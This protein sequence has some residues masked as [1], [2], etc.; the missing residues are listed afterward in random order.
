[1]TKRPTAPGWSARP[2]DHDKIPIRVTWWRG[3]GDHDFEEYDEEAFSSYM[4]ALTSVVATYG[5]SAT[6]RALNND[7]GGGIF[8]LN[9]DLGFS[10]DR[11]KGDN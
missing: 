6:H 10:L 1:M 3:V 11:L 5:E 8:W 4:E 7:Q 9:D 2:A